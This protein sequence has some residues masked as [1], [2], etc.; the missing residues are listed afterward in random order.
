[1]EDFP[2]EKTMLKINPNAAGIDTFI[3]EVD[4]LHKGFGTVYIRKF[5]KE[6]TFKESEITSCIIDPEP[7]NKIAISAYQK[8]GFRY[9]HRAW[10]AEDNVAAYVMTINRESIFKPPAVL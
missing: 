9:S 2:T 6:I 4:F 1:M 7:S 8:A 5:L 10:N 3:G